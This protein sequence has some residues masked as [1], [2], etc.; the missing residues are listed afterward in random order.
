LPR[1]FVK[2]RHDGLLANRGRTE[3]LTVCRAL[4]AVW[5]MAQL[6]AGILAS[7]ATRGSDPRRCPACG[8]AQWRAVTELPRSA[9]AAPVEAA[10]PAPAPDTS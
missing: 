10:T 4:L 9:T 2:I 8:A 1:G 3:R 7:E 6:V 5:T